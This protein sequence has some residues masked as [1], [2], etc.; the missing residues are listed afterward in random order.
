MSLEIMFIIIITIRLG[1]LLELVQFSLKS[2]YSF[3]TSVFFRQQPASHAIKT[4]IVFFHS[5]FDDLFPLGIKLLILGLCS[6][7]S[8]A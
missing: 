6:Y 1:Q 3:N 4:A 2:F 8:L 5:R 7:L